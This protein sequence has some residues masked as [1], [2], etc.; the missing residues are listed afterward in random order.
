MWYNNLKIA[1][2]RFG[3]Q[4]MY[5]FINVM[6]LA[7]GLVAGIFIF[8]Y[9]QDELSY[10]RFNENGARIYRLTE[11]F[12]NGDEWTTTAMTP[13]K[14]APLLAEYSPAVVDF[15][16]FDTDIGR[17][18]IQIIEYGDKR[19]ETSSITYADSTVF[20]VF[21][22]PLLQ[23][24]PKKALAEPNTVVIAQTAA[25]A[26]FGAEDPM[27][28]A[29]SVRDE[30]TDS[31]FEVTVN[32]IMQD[33][34][35]NAHNHYDF[36]VS[37]ATGDE[38]MPGRM[39]SWGWTSQYS[40]V[41]LAEGHYIREVETALTEI[42]KEH[43][44]DWFNKWAGFGTQPL[45]DIHLY[46]N[47][48]DEVE[49]NGSVWNVYIFSLVGLF[50]LL[51][52]CINYMNLTTA[53]A[54]NRAREVGMRKVIGARYQQLVKQFLG[55]SMLV[56][57]LAFLVA[58]SL[59]LILLPFFN[60]LTGKG[61]SSADFW[62]P[63]LLLTWTGIVALVGFLA[64]SYPAFF[65]ASF[66][67]MKVL[68]G[69]FSKNGRQTLVLRKVLVVAQFSISIALIVGIMVIYDQWD[70]LRN[71]RL[72][73][74]TEQM[75][76]IPIRSGEM[77]EQYP[78]FKQESEK[79]SGVLGT[80]ATS[81]NPLSVFTNYGTFDVGTEADDYSVP[82]VGIDENFTK[83]YDIEVASGRTFRSFEADSNSVLLNE[84][85]AKLIGM[86]D[87]IGQVL[88]F[89]DNYQPRVVGVVK[90]FNFESLHA[91]IRPMYFYPTTG[92]FQV[93]AVKVA[94]DNVAGTIDGLASVW[95]DLGLTESF[96][97]TF[98]DEDINQ[99]YQA[100]ALFL[101]VFAT[102]GIVAIFIAC[103]GLFGLA[104]FTVE[105]RTKEIGIRKVLGANITN[106]VALLSKDF[107]RLVLIAALVA[108][109]VA[110]YAMERWLENFAYRITIPWY[111]FVLSVVLAVGVAFVTVSFQSIKAALT[112]PVK[113]LRSE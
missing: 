104:A 16:R 93:V 9:V 4:P 102:L 111:V 42:K 44:P 54:A 56:T 11:T 73:I 5:S 106:L 76:M 51:I 92:D 47:V 29:I 63:G 84:S 49:A 98:L 34:P 103:L 3:K 96:S 85:A 60:Q 82:G 53:R 107:L 110:W 33:M 14:I 20:E 94:P 81:K 87:P 40:Y 22:F 32:G 17:G 105:Q 88:K 70:F 48:K 90:D 8:M 108:F 83:V 19:Y 21:T 61:L 75:L 10:D 68:K 39:E 65:L 72:G 95:S 58:T 52:A 46:S 109:P 30:F 59:V 6:G 112:N 62:Q 101:Q 12:K 27:G 43:A 50:I 67:P 38:Q 41:L 71:K 26:I 23:G 77:L 35:E 15:V 113:S 100:E 74:N 78:I 66:Q 24:D 31:Q 7:I 2:R 1:L 25:K 99:H 28:R 45:L 13:Y 79:L 55:E 97:F 36:L 80:T 64:G 69:F 86:E 57:F 37:K 91:E 89:S 18:D